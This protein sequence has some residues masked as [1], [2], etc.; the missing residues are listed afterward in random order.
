MNTKPAWSVC[1]V[2][3]PMKLCLTALF[4]CQACLAPALMAYTKA[5][6][7]V[8]Q[9]IDK[10]IPFLEQ[11]SENRLGGKS[12]VAMVFLKTGH[13]RDHPKIK[14]AI[15]ACQRTRTRSGGRTRARACA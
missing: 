10:A 5:S 15:A 9:L 8:K 2:Q 4:L 11:G 7:E 13:E 1:L 14:D 12:A 6:P 3:W